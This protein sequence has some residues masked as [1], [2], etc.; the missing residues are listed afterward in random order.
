MLYTNT[1]HRVRLFTT[2]L[3]N[4]KQFVHVEEYQMFRDKFPILHQC[5]QVHQIV[6]WHLQSYLEAQSDHRTVRRILKITLQGL[7]TPYGMSY[8]LLGQYVI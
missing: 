6:Y 7:N 1:N 2:C 8:A 5:I 3:D 4:K